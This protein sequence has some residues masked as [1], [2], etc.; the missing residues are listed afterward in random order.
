M[1]QTTPISQALLQSSLFKLYTFQVQRLFWS[2][3]TALMHSAPPA[4]GTPRL[5]FL[6]P[7]LLY[8]T[9]ESVC[10]PLVEHMNLAPGRMIL[11]SCLGNV[12]CSAPCFLY[13]STSYCSSSCYSSCYSISY[14]ILSCSLSLSLASFLSSFL[15]PAFYLAAFFGNQILHAQSFTHI[16]S[17]TLTAL[18]DSTSGARPCWGG[19]GWMDGW[20][21]WWTDGWMNEWT[22]ERMNE[23][24]TE[25]MGEWMNEWVTEWMGEWMNEC[26]NAWMNEWMKEWMNE[27]N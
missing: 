23:W 7:S 12:A 16:C 13:C 1:L 19:S 15:S 21:D 4:S 3:G 20:M 17:F 5:L 9:M 2:A 24:V 26:M 6:A 25:W 22:N 11:I 18:L 10:K 14:C 8:Q 27:W